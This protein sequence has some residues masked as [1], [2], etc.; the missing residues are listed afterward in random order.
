MTEER[1]RYYAEKFALSL[2]VPFYVVR[3]RKDQLYAVQVPS[4]DCEV[5]ATFAPPT[6]VQDQRLKTT[7]TTRASG[8]RAA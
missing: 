3:S 6:R 5:L 1:A 7:T 4:D 8:C 2:G